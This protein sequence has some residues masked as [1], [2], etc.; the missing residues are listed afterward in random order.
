MGH[1]AVVALRVL[2]V[3]IL[4][5]SV[6]AQLVFFPVLAGQLAEVHPELAWLRWP[7]LAVVVLVILVGQL[8]VAAVWVLLTMVQ[9]DSVFSERA[10]VWVDLV[11]GAA[12]LDAL[13]VLA[14]NAFLSFGLHANP[15]GLMLTL[16]AL[17]VAGAAVACLMVVMKG[18]LRKASTLKAELSE[19]I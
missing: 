7:L 19:V 2:L 12:V 13:L 3:V 1:K 14:V 10:F 18:L 16:L 4:V 11:I 6:A 8:A 17:T 15:P 9:H 5:G